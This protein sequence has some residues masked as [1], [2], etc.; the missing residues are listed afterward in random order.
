MTISDITPAA[1]VTLG[2]TDTP[3]S[4]TSNEGLYFININYGASGFLEE[5]AYRDGAFQG[6]FAA[7]STKVG[8]VYT[9]RRNGGWPA[10]PSPVVEEGAPPVV[11]SFWETIEDIDLTAFATQTL[12]NNY[13]SYGQYTIDGYTFSL[14]G[15]GFAE[16]PSK[17]YF[18]N[19]RGVRI[20]ASGGLPG[21]SF[22]N[23]YPPTF[24]LRVSDLPQWD[25]SKWTAALLRFDAPSAGG[26]LQNNTAIAASVWWDPGGPTYHSIG[27]SVLAAGVA[28][29]SSV[30]G[31]FFSDTT[32]T[33]GQSRGGMMGFKANSAPAKDFA[34]G[35]L[36]HPNKVRRM[37]GV[38]YKPGLASLPAVEDL[39]WFGGGD[40][41]TLFCT[42]SLHMGMSL[43][44]A[45]GGVAGTSEYYLTQIRI[46]QKAAA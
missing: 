15:A 4:F 8:N 19:G 30:N 14:T 17:A 45:S 35:V 13:D 37:A 5:C 40:G 39:Y 43:G 9:L 36:V 12:T 22:A 33:F 34:L 29:D 38:F 31:R 46:L 21:G 32:Q 42:G 20:R 16:T 25:P 44:T 23:I 24:A 1:G 41:S 3:F 11:T 10:E 7:Q 6:L 26:N 27:N 18:E 28:Q 2:G